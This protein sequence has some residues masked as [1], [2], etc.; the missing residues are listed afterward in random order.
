MDTDESSKSG[1]TSI[2]G[3]IALVGTIAIIGG[4][5]IMTQ[6]GGGSD[7]KSQAFTTANQVD[8]DNAPGSGNSDASDSQKFGASV[9]VLG[10]P[11]NGFSYNVQAGATKL[12]T[13]YTTSQHGQVVAKPGEYFLATPIKITNL[14][15]DRPSPE[16]NDEFNFAYYFNANDVPHNLVSDCRF[17]SNHAGYSAEV[18]PGAPRIDPESKCSDPG[19]DV[20]FNP[21]TGYELGCDIGGYCQDTTHIEP[22]GSI[23]LILYSGSGTFTNLDATDDAVTDVWSTAHEGDGIRFQAWSIPSPT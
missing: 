16:L 11:S 15:G 4:V 8:T 19:A 9:K 13:S 17:P 10:A 5:I 6:I 23:V 1:R 12:V 7:T 3:V 20:V 21:G 22:G 18:K 14:V 2:L